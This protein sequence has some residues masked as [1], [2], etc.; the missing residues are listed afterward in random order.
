MAIMEPLCILRACEQMLC[1]ASI[2][3]MLEQ[4]LSKSIHSSRRIH[5]GAGILYVPLLGGFGDMFPSRSCCPARTRGPGTRVGK[6]PSVRRLSL[7]EEEAFQALNRRHGKGHLEVCDGETLTN[8]AFCLTLSDIFGEPA[9]SNESIQGVAGKWSWTP[10]DVA[11]CMCDIKGCFFN[12][13]TRKMKGGA[14]PFTKLSGERNAG[15]WRRGL[16]DRSSSHVESGEVCCAE[17][18]SK[19]LVSISP[20]EFR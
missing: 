14:H 12:P 15:S 20:I 7:H 3:D 13:L 1:F 2:K 4:G 5:S 8:V 18:R 10:I 6:L 9:K 19:K 11:M 17:R 16:L